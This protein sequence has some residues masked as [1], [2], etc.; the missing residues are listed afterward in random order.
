MCVQMHK[1]EIKSQQKSNAQ[2]KYRT[3]KVVLVLRYSQ[4]LVSLTRCYIENEYV[5]VC[6]CSLDVDKSKRC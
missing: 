1:V 5:Y 2:A 6:R 3:V 4:H